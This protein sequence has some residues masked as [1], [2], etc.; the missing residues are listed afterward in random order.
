MLGGTKRRA[1]AINWDRVYSRLWRLIDASGDCYFSGPRFLDK[2]REV[3]LDLP[4][5]GRFIESRRLA[6]KSTSRQNYFYDVLMELDEPARW[7]AVNAI[8]EEVEHCDSNLVSEIRAAMG[9]PG[10]APTATV[11][12]DIWNAE[13]L[14]GFLADIDAAIGSREYGQAVTLSYTCLEGFYGAFFWAK[15]PGQSAPN[16]IV[17]LSRWIRDY[18]RSSIAEYPDEVLNLINHTSHAIDRAR[19]RFSE[20]HFGGEAGRWLATYVRDLVNIQIRLLLHFM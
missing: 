4:G 3:D 15:A 7:R 14:N 13:R 19:N 12:A 20:S 16:E 9:G 8:L 17:A 10:A 5:Y 18:L 11:R 1:M 2:V 6:G